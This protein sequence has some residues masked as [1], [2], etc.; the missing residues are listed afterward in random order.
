LFFSIRMGIT[1]IIRNRTRTLVALAGGLLAITLIAGANISV[2]VAT[3][4]VLALALEESPLDLI[5]LMEDVEDLSVVSEELEA[6][7]EIEVTEPVVVAAAELLLNVSPTE[8]RQMWTGVLGVEPGFDRLADKLGFDED[9]DFDLG[10][11]EILITQDFLRWLEA[12]GSDISTG[13]EIEL[14]YYSPVF[15]EREETYRWECNAFRIAGFMGIEALD[16]PFFYGNIELVTNTETARRM[17]FG[18]EGPFPIGLPGVRVEAPRSI[19]A[20]WGVDFPGGLSVT[21]YLVL[22][23]RE[24]VILPADI[25]GTRDN[26]EDLRYEI[27]LA[28]GGDIISLESPIENV[29]EIYSGELDVVR[30]I[31]LVGSLPVIALGIYLAMIGIDVGFGRRRTEVAL[32]KCR[33]ASAQQITNLFMTESVILGIIAGIV[34]LL[35]GA[36]TTSL[37]IVPLPEGQTL[38]LSPADLSRIGISITTASI[39]VV[40]GVVIM[41]IA[42]FRPVRRIRNID[43][44]EALGKYSASYEREEYRRRLDLVFVILPL[45]IYT[46]ILFIEEIGRMPTLLAFVLMIAM[47]V[48]VLILPFTPL[49]LILGITRLLTRGTSRTYEITSRVFKPV[50]GELHPLI[51]RNLSRNPRRTARVAALIAL[52]LAFGT[53]I[54]VY[55][56]SDEVSMLSNLEFSI[57]A[58]VK[59]SDPGTLSADDLEEIEG[60]QD[61]CDIVMAR[62][63]FWYMAIYG[64]DPGE[65]ENCVGENRFFSRR[66]E[67]LLEEL[68][69]T[70]NGALVFISDDQVPWEEGEEVRLPVDSYMGDETAYINFTLLGFFRNA[71]GL[72]DTLY[73]YGSAMIM[74]RD[75]LEAQLTVEPDEGYIL[76]KASEG[77]NQTDLAGRILDENPGLHEGNVESVEGELKVLRDPFIR[78]AYSFMELEF[79]FT[80]IMATFG[81]GLIMFMAATERENEVAGLVARGMGKIQVMKVMTGE[82]FSIV[83]LGFAIGVP[84][85][86]F[87][88]FVLRTAMMKA[89]NLTI[90]API[91]FPLLLFLLLGLTAVAL[92]VASLVSSIKVSRISLSEALRVR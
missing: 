40:L 2:D 12:E 74:K 27:R 62:S 20:N 69:A 10:D 5:V 70:E 25:D 50:V 88:V 9:V 29:I 6:F 80:L 22:V 18:S 67:G 75:A 85:G 28:L 81:L 92:V 54:M 51:A 86:L 48:G 91:V 58:D 57:G 78:A 21:S 38:S 53:F 45:F 76:V 36:L 34:G 71:P 46:T 66:L 73:R 19:D 44:I 24:Q 17:G 77:V 11:D 84:V 23:D 1:N 47:S 39:C 31:F 65:Y 83:L 64:L 43:I 26:L 13:D 61:A 60:V 16:M 30:V 15:G 56:K 72:E 32:L 52:S 68:E 59:I 35:L 82:A 49:M 79:A 8:S 14:C 42:S 4:K 87:T 55:S 89:M 3:Q 41:F 33:G 37:I 63:S 7:D 90:P